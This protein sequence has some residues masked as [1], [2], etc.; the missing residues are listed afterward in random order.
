N[1]G[2]A[3]NTWSTQGRI[4]MRPSIVTRPH[5]RPANI[6]RHLWLS[7][8]AHESVPAKSSRL[9]VTR[10]TNDADLDEDTIGDSTNAVPGRAVPGSHVRSRSE[11]QPGRPRRLR[12][13]LELRH[14][15]STR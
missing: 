12:R 4:F 14:R 10:W 13:H 9:S 1:K 2:S 7:L 8:P 3:S 15:D 6:M 5:S 11:R